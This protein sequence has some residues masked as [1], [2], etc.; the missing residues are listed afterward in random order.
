[1]ERSY[2]AK[3]SSKKLTKLLLTDSIPQEDKNTV[4]QL[5]LDRLE[6]IQI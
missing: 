1:M 5:L 4:K 6:A 3:M 2:Y